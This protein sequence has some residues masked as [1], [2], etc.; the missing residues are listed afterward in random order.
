MARCDFICI[1]W[2]KLCGKRSKQEFQIH[3]RY[4]IAFSF[5][6]CFSSA[7]V[8]LRIRLLVW[9][10]IFHIFWIMRKY[11]RRVFLE[12]NILPLVATYVLVVAV[13]KCDH[14]LKENLKFYTFHENVYL[15]E[16]QMKEAALIFY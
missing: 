8:F 13:V 6:R 5:K 12:K 11:F 14:Q 4:F 9:V 7:P 1:G 2:F 10:D 15:A 16:K 3:A